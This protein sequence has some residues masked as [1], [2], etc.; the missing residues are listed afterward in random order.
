M[1]V[2]HVMQVKPFWEGIALQQQLELLSLYVRLLRT[3]AAGVTGGFSSS[4]CSRHTDATLAHAVNGFSVKKAT[5]TASISLQPIMHAKS[6]LPLSL[7]EFKY[8]SLLTK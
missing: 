6:M 1:Q 7:R 4:C 8:I 2:K 5:R 3:Q